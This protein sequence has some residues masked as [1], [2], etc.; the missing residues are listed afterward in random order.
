VLVR[1]SHAGG[2]SRVAPGALVAGHVVVA[3]AADSAD[4]VGRSDARV[5]DGAIAGL[6]TTDAVAAR[7]RPEPGARDAAGDLRSARS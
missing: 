4:R 1:A 2:S 6:P 7:V 3:Q 5:Y